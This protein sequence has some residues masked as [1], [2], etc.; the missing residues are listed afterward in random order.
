MTHATETSPPPR[1]AAGPRRVPRRAARTAR[2]TRT[3]PTVAA[4]SGPRAP[5]ELRRDLRP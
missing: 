1:Q 3:A 5:G 2:R 4:R